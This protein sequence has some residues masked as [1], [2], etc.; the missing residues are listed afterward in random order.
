MQKHFMALDV[1]F[2]QICLVIFLHMFTGYDGLIVC[3]VF[4]QPSSQFDAK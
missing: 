3:T 1:L 2:Q 4:L